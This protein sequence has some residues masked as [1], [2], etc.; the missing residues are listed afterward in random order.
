MKK[1]ILLWD[2]TVSSEINTEL[3]CYIPDNQAHKCAIVIFPGGGYW[4][5]AEHEGKGYAE[6]L[7]AH[8][9]A[10]FVC[11]YHVYPHQFPVQLLDARR[12]IRYVRHYAAQFGIDK[13]HVYVMGSS[14]GGHL[15]A[16]VSSYYEPIPGEDADAVDQ[17]CYIPNGQIL[18]YPVIKLLGKDVAHLDSGKNLLGDRQA[19]MG[20]E[21]SPDLIATSKAPKAFIWHTFTDS[22]VSVLNSMDYAKRLWSNQV[23]VEL[24][25]YPQG[26]HGLGLAPN[27][28][29][30]AQWS[31]S[32]LRWLALYEK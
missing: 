32:L 11:Q 26:E 3:D 2:K 17:E 24:H 18:C 27:D 4:G 19:A 16:L 29:H 20:E 30:V 5:R 14:A 12:A 31:E 9:I 28:P 13:D 22:C 1:T 15:A 10:A 7:N 8:G 23:E 21:L 6:F 25:I